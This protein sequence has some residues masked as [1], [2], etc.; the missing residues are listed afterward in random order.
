MTAMVLGTSARMC[1][2]WGA[3]R[4]DIHRSTDAYEEWLRHRLGG[5]LVEKALARK[6]EKMRKDAFSF[7]RATYWRWAETV[8]VV[9]PGAADAPP[10]LGV[11]DVH[12][13]NFGTWRDADGRLAGGVNDFDEAAEMP[14]VLDLIRLATSALLAAPDSGVAPA[15]ICRAL[16][17]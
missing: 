16:L 12:L 9:C 10:V 2:R 8:L 11:G 4:N 15:V 3:K 7:L 14:Y 6:H 1:V 13:E 5:D 17:R